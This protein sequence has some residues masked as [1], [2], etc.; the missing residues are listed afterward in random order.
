VRS[1]GVEHLV[2][3]PGACPHSNVLQVNEKTDIQSG[4][5]MAVSCSE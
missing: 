5:T 1:A 2:P 3:E 4:S